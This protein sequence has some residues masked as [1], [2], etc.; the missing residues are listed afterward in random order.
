MDLLDMGRSIHDIGRRLRWSDVGTIIRHLPASSHLIRQQNPDRGDLMY[1]SPERELLTIVVD[2]VRR[3]RWQ[4]RGAQ[5]MPTP[6]LDAL[7][8]GA[9]DKPAKKKPERERGAHSAKEAR[10]MLAA[11]KKR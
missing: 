8:G 6:M 2:E 10:A 5:E 4:M 9:G 7:R 3:L 11:A 1:L